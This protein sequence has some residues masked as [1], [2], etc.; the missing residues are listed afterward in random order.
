MRAY[1]LADLFNLDL[2]PTGRLPGFAD[3]RFGLERLTDRVL[4]TVPSAREVST[5]VR[6]RRLK[7]QVENAPGCLLG[8]DRCSL[9][10]FKSWCAGRCP[11]TGCPVHLQDVASRY[12]QKMIDTLLTADA[13]AIRYERLADAV[14]L[15]SDDDDM[16]PAML[17]LAASDVSLVHLTKRKRRSF[18]RDVLEREGAR[19]HE[20]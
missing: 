3:V 19:I 7:T 10:S 12:A 8:P 11:E 5:H 18:Y 13:M 9:S 17:A 14:V 6:S 1:C 4:T 20:W 15:A 16:I 2:W